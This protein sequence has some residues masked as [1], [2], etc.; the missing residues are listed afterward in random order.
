MNG[1][2]QRSCISDCLSSSRE[3]TIKRSGVDVRVTRSTNARPNEPVPPVIKTCLPLR[4]QSGGL[5]K[6]WDEDDADRS[7]A[8]S[9][10]PFI[11]RC[12]FDLQITPAHQ[13]LS[14]PVGPGATR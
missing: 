2:F 6:P 7:L 13:G 9:V 12:S 10:M 4:S 14:V 8:V 3:N 5:G 11:C 1:L